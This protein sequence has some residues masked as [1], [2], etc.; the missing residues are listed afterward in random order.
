MRCPACLQSG[1]EV[2]A[3]R[4]GIEGWIVRRKRGCPACG[5]TFITVE[6][7]GEELE[8]LQRAAALF[9]AMRNIAVDMTEPSPQKRSRRRS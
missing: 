9:E 4:Q 7:L 8:E 3:T 5:E 1:L 6:I 2:H